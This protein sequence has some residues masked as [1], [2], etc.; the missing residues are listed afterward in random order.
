MK[1]SFCVLLLALLTASSSVRAQ[2]QFVT[3]DKL[4]AGIY[5]VRSE[6]GTQFVN[7]MPLGNGS[8]SFYSS[9]GSSSVMTLAPGIYTLTTSA[10]VNVGTTYIYSLGNGRYSFSNPST[11]TTGSIQTFEPAPTPPLAALAIQPPTNN[12]ENMT[13]LLLLAAMARQQC[14]EHGGIFYRP[15]WYSSVRCEAPAEIESEREAKERKKQTTAEYD[16]QANEPRQNPAQTYTSTS[17]AYQVFS[18][19]SSSAYGVVYVSSNQNGTEIYVD[20]SFVTKAPL[21]LNLKPGQHYVRAFLKDYKNWSQQITVS[22]GSQAHL[23]VTL[24]KADY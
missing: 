18:T 20:D 24:E 7:V 15:H 5:T 4:A 3:I 8:Y 19:H 6:A 17:L 22:A 2:T 21:T 9:D 14:Y 13:S 1:I 12:L 16:K 11:G 10:G 23:T